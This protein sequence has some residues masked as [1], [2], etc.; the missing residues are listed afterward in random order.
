VILSIRATTLV[1][2]SDSGCVAGVRTYEIVVWEKIGRV[3]I[4]AIGTDSASF[5]AGMTTFLAREPT[6]TRLMSC[7]T[8]YLTGPRLGESILASWID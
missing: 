3:F 8:S 4:E 2:V 1:S 6:E 5:A 7:R